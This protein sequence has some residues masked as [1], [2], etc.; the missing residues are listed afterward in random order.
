MVVAIVTHTGLALGIATVINH[1]SG[2]YLLPAL[3]LIMIT[4]LVLGMGM[5]CT[6]AYIIAITIGGPALVALGVNLLAA[7]LLVFYFAILAEVTPPVCIPAYCAASI[8]GAKPLQTGFEAFK[9]AIVAFTIPHIFVFNHALLLRGGL[10]ETVS[11]VLVIILS[12]I[13]LSSAM[14]GYFFKMLNAFE[15]AIM[16]GAAGAGVILSGHREWVGQPLTLAAAAAV[17]TAFLLWAVLRKKK[18]KRMTPEGR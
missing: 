4:S 1:W 11:L 2:G 10:V 18:L 9:M 6:P 17:A 5:P 13:F 7:H 3:I 8:A 12:V 14:T 16:A 15:K